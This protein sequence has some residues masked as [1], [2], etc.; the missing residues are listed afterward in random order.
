MENDGQMNLRWKIKK[1]MNGISKRSSREIDIALKTFMIFKFLG[2][3]KGKI[4]QDSQCVLSN[5]Q[6]WIDQS[7]STSRSILFCC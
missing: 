1:K 5:I 2:R 4:V 7:F 3:V 6:S